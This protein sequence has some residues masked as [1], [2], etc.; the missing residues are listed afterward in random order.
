MASIKTVL[1]EILSTF[2][3]KSRTSAKQL[4]DQLH[5]GWPVSNSSVAM[6]QLGKEL[7]D[8]MKQSLEVVSVVP[9]TA[10][11]AVLLVHLSERGGGREVTPSY[12]YSAIV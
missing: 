7:R 6:Q 10:L 9:P 5:L 12:H 2:D 4:R 8:E 11:V 1:M 3:A